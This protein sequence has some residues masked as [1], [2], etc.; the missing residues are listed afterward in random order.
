MTGEHLPDRSDSAGTLWLDVA[1]RDWNDEMLAATRLTRAAMPG[2]VEGSEPAGMLRTEV[3]EAWGV[4]R[5]P[6]ACLVAGGG[7]RPGRRSGAGVIDGS[8]ASLSLGTSP[9]RPGHRPAA[10]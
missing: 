6:G 5:V 8:Q 2:L 7:R 3:A 10:A 9:P 4:R 1:R